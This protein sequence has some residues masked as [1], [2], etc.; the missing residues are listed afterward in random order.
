MIWLV[1]ACGSNGSEQKMEAP[2]AVVTDKTPEQRSKKSEK[3]QNHQ[4]QRSY[5]MVSRLLLNGMTEILFMA[6][7]PMVRK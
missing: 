1:L 7:Q 5:W 4:N 3:R 2:A 6:R